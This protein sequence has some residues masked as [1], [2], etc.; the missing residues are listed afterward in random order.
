MADW[1]KLG[2]RFIITRR[3]LRRFGGVLAVI[4]FWLF[5]AVQ[6]VSNQQSQRLI[7]MV[8]F[9][10]LIGTAAAM[11][12]KTRKLALPLQPHIRRGLIYF[13]V[14]ALTL[15]RFTMECITCQGIPLA[16]LALASMTYVLGVELTDRAIVF[17]TL[18]SGSLL[19]LGISRRELGPDFK[20][21][22][23]RSDF[24]LD[25]HSGN[26]DQI[27]CDSRE[28]ARANSKS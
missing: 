8:F 9:W 4:G 25:P 12:L 13:E 11:L 17:V 5:F 20:N 18:I 1:P 7:E 23:R 21:R 10:L 22:R 3:L 14:Q 15:R 26:H 24:L 28:P 2:S 27:G 19:G 16:Y 6:D